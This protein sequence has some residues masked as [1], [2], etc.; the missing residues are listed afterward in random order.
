MIKALLSTFGRINAFH[1]KADARYFDCVTV[2]DASFAGADLDGLH[3]KCQQG[4]AKQGGQ[5]WQ[6]VHDC[7]KQLWAARIPP[8]AHV[9]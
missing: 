7:S 3:R 9:C 1:S 5:K 8:I 2:D 4:K 6:A